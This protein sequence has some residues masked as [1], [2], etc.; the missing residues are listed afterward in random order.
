MS[1]PPI[2][3]TNK[4]LPFNDLSPLEFERMCLWLVEREGYLRPQHL[5]EGGS[6]QGRDVVAYKPT[7]AGDELW[8]FQ[9]KRV[10]KIGASGLRKEVDKILA[11][12]EQEPDKRP[13]GIIFV[14]TC[15]VPAAARDKTK[16]FCREHNLAC[17]F[18][19]WS[20]LDLR[21]KK[22]RHVVQEFFNLPY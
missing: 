6:E 17:H 1:K 4:P 22:H 3:S 13:V 16:E 18:W 5:G 14:I 21:T 7:D 11:L 9:C 10:K 20:E 2:Y 15:D 8:Y 19:A 12:I